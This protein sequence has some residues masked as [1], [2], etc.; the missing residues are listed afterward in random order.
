MLK[1]FFLAISRTS[2]GQ[3]LHGMESNWRYG[4]RLVV[5]MCG[6]WRDSDWS[7]LGLAVF[8]FRKSFC[9]RDSLR[10]RHIIKPVHLKVFQ[11]IQLAAGP[12][13]LEQLNFICGAD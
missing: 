7:V 8:G 12:A 4:N 3:F 1:P 9:A 2:A 13:D 5:R 11:R 6:C 10:F